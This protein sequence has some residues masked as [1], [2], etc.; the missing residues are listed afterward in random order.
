[1]LTPDGARSSRRGHAD[2]VLVTL[3]RAELTTRMAE[4]IERACVELGEEG[5]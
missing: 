3:Q 5:A 1:V 4:E 2:D